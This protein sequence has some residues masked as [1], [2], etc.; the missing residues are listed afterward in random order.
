MPKNILVL[1]LNEKVVDC[2]LPN[3]SILDGF[4][5]NLSSIQLARWLC[6]CFVAGMLNVGI[7]YLGST[8]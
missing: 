1:D 3:R 5:E 6:A 8:Q 7:V 2:N 4:V